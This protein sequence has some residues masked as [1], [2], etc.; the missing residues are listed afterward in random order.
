MREFDPFK[1]QVVEFIAAYLLVSLLYLVCCFLITRPETGGQPDLPPQTSQRRVLLL[2]WVAGIAFRLTLAGLDPQLSEDLNRYRW[3]GKL[4]MAGGNPYTEAPQDP[5][6]LGLRDSTWPEV[7]RK[8]LTSAY[9][10]VYELLYAGYYRMVAAFEPDERRQVWLFKIPFALLELAVAAALAQLLGLMGRP[11]GWL[12]VYFWSPLMVVEFWAQGHNDTLTVLLVLL[13]LIAAQR[14]KFVWAFGWLSLATLAKFWP[15]VLFPF[16]LVERESGRW[17]I[18]WKPA[19]ISL[20]IAL[21]VSWP[22]LEGLSNVTEL[23]GGFVGG[24]RNND[25]LYGWIY[26]AVNEDFERGKQVVVRL[27]VVSLGLL[28]TL[29]LPLV[30][31]AKWAVVLLLFLSANCF[32]WY[33]SWLLPFLAVYPQ[34]ALLLWTTL[35]V[36][37]YQILIGYEILGVWQDSDLF[38]LMEYLPVYGL[39]LARLVIAS[40]PALFERLRA[41]RAKTT[42]A[43]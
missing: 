2:I 10:P 23:L 28:W 19:L 24:W 12:L 14:R 34:A 21:A 20:P 39:L 38:R 40:L 41:V 32:P 5:R 3:Q 8:D 22:Y 42:P 33:L 26:W 17:I 4:Q 29:G 43:G 11:P 35:V 18:R 36:L 15:A 31:S 30:R 9:G 16:L 6:W 25:S 37:S 27:L 7:N 1:R 13:A